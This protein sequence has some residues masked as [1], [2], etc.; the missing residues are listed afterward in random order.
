ML[1]FQRGEKMTREEVN[2]ITSLADVNA[3]GRFDYIKVYKLML[4]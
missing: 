3:D 2:A 4:T 1:F